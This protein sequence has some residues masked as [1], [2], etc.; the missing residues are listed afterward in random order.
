[1]KTYKVPPELLAVIE[2]A[3]T[4]KKEQTIFLP[5]KPSAFVKYVSDGS[6]RIDTLP[7]SSAVNSQ[8]R[9]YKVEEMQWFVYYEERPEV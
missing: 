2:R 8:G 5:H 4:E 6:I 7:A 9:V 1:M 3:K